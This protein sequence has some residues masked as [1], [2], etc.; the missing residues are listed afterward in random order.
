MIHS[1][2]KF[3][4]NTLLV[5]SKPMKR[6]MLW[7]THRLEVHWAAFQA[8]LWLWPSIAWA[9]E[10]LLSEPSFYPSSKQQKDGYGLSRPLTD[11]TDIT[12]LM[13]FVLGGKKNGDS[14]SFQCYLVLKRRDI[15][16]KGR[17]LGV[18]MNDMTDTLPC[19]KQVTFE[20]KTEVGE[21]QTFMWA[22]HLHTGRSR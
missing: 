14:E 17:S 18:T 20:Q 9:M 12:S 3:S 1:L 7:K 10:K 5:S 21:R 16:D 6:G 2:H 4:V 11:S 15:K 19:L 22:K 13:E 8:W